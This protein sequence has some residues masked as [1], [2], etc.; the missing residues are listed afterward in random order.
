MPEDMILY[1]MTRSEQQT[2]DDKR[3]Q[4]KCKREEAKALAAP[5]VAPTPPSRTCR[6]R[7]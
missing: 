1:K 4:K 7:S 5:A 2:R 3:E 6:K